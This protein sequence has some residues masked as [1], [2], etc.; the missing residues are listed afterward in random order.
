VLVAQSFQKIPALHTLAPKGSEPPFGAAQGIVL[1][2]F[3]IAGY[4]S[5]RRFHPA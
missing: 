3:L 4:L 1:V 5:V 2:A